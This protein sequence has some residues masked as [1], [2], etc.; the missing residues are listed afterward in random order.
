MSRL[1]R[2]ARAAVAETGSRRIPGDD[3]VDWLAGQAPRSKL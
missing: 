1:I 2:L 3:V